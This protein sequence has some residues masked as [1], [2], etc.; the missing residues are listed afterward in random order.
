M[1]GVLNINPMNE[2]TTSMKR[3][4]NKYRTICSVKAKE[5]FRLTSYSL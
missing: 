5:W 1:I 4:A 2:N 3:F